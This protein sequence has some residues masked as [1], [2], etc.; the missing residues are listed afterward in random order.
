MASLAYPNMVLGISN[1]V[2]H[3]PSFNSV[4]KS[5]ANTN[6]SSWNSGD[7]DPQ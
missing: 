2:R 6:I 3:T 4:P 1:S 5:H 7:V